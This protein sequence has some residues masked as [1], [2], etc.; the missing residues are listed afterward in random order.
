LLSSRPRTDLLRPPN[1]RRHDVERGNDDVGI[2]PFSPVLEKTLHER[3]HPI[4]VIDLNDQEVTRTEVSKGVLEDVQLPSG[5]T[6]P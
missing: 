3:D 2:G 5:P 4:D 6:F 1:D